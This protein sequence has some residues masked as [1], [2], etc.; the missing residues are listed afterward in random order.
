MSGPNLDQVVEWL[1]KAGAT[2]PLMATYQLQDEQIRKFAELAYAAGQ[3][4]VY[5]TSDDF[6]YADLQGWDIDGAT[7]FNL[8]DRHADGW[9]GIGL[10][11]EKWRDQAVAAEREACAK[12]AND[13]YAEARSDETSFAI[14]ARGDK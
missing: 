13:L 1:Q 10:M 5:P 11:M 8:I 6:E 14:R 4:S 2:S 3:E 12:L 9:S 7:A